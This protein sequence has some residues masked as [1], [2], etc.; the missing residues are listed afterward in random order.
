MSF[1]YITGIETAGK[2]TVCRELKN[3]GFEAYDI[4]E[5][6]AHYYDKATGEQSEWL[7]AAEART[8]EW[9]ETRAYMMDR[10][11][12]ERIKAQ[13]KDKPIFLCGTTQNDEIVLDLFDKLI[14][15][16]LDEDTLRD[17]MSKRSSTELAFA[18][19]EQQ[20][21]LSWHKPCEDKYRK[22]GATM[23]DATQPNDKVIESILAAII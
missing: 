9:H 5:G 20:A 10:S 8:S 4:D 7:G 2:S 15:L 19:H 11:H 23:V 17:R 13:A 16:Y 3:R 1:I 22:L 21:V 18:P 12:V 14:Y 6:I